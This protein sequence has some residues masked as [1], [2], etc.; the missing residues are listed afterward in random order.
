MV[1]E[2]SVANSVHDRI[3]NALFCVILHELFT[4]WVVSDCDSG[5]L[6]LAKNPEQDQLPTTRNLLYLRETALRILSP[7][8]SSWVQPAKVLVAPW[9]WY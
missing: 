9:W 2:R 4:R 3:S 6:N 5:K 1:N 8:G 7:I